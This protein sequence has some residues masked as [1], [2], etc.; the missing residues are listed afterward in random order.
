MDYI[1]NDTASEPKRPAS[2]YRS[3]EPQKW[4]P[5]HELDLISAGMT[6]PAGPDAPAYPSISVSLFSTAINAAAHKAEPIAFPLLVQLIQEGQWRPRIE[7]VRA[8]AEWK[9][10]TV[11]KVGKEGEAVY[12]GTATLSGLNLPGPISTTRPRIIWHIGCRPDCGI[13]CI[14]T[15]TAGST[16]APP[17][18]AM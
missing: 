3:N 14:V 5:F 2:G 4:R 16:P 18:H 9:L 12:T 17:R 1:T 7:P 11:E 8:L 15:P 6:S 13:P 10:E